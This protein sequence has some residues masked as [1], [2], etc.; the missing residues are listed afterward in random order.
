MQN[1]QKCTETCFY[2]VLLP[3]FIYDFSE[4][5]VNMAQTVQET[6]LVELA[7]IVAELPFVS[8]IASFKSS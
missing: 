5:L 7:S 4:R 6:G 8:R 1:C 3:G 2:G